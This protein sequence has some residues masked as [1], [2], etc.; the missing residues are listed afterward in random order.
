[1]SMA[2]MSFA[3]G[4]HG[5][6]T[7]LLV[8]SE[9]GRLADTAMALSDRAAGICPVGVILPKRRGF[10]VPIGERLYDRSSVAEQAEGEPP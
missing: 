4:G 3:V 10:A 2:S 8:D 5:I 1:M 6:G 9:S 7:H